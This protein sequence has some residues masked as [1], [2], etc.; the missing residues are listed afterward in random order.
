MFSEQRGAAVLRCIGCA[1]LGGAVVAGFNARGNIGVLA[2]AAIATVSIAF[3]AMTRRL[4]CMRRSCQSAEAANRAKTEFLAKVSHEIRTPLNGILATAEL[5]ERS[6]LS[7]EQHELVQ[8]ILGSSDALTGILN[9][10]LDFSRIE[11]GG[12]TLECAPFALHEVLDE[13]ERCYAER[14]KA[15]GLEFFT[16]VA[17]G[18]PAAIEGDALRL[19]QVLSNLLSNALKFT[20]AGKVSLEVCPAES[21]DAGTALVFRVRDSGIGIE[22][23]VMDRL[24]AAFTQGESSDRRRYGG[25]GLGLAIARRLASLMGG[26]IGVDSRVGKGSTFWLLLPVRAVPVLSAQKAEPLPPKRR[27]RILI[28]D[29]NPVNQLVVLRAVTGMGF[30]AEVVSSGDAVLESLERSRFQLVLMDCQMPGMDGYQAAALIRE[31][32]RSTPNAKRIP[33]VAMTANVVEGDVERCRES[34]M[35]DYLAKP[36]RVAQLAATLDR[37]LKPP[38]H[39]SVMKAPVGAYARETA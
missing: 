36:F 30:S 19:R 11:R 39:E 4:C 2:A 17:P 24:F 16:S 31:R 22:P 7:A 37:W 1:L 32:E 12:L 34:G 6:G 38:L 23:A 8:T 3:L 29:D 33:I 15:K 13:L 25:M 26:T 18:V 35:D 5:L 28:A 14:A 27:E 20:P 21:P 9:D 10:V